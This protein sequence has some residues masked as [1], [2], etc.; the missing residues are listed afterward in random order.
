MSFLHVSGKTNLGSNTVDTIT[1]TGMRRT[2]SSDAGQ[3]L[4]IAILGALEVRR[5]DVVLGPDQLGGPKARQIL[6]ILLLNLGVP[7]SKGR[8]IDLLWDGAAPAAAVSTL[9]SYV[10][11]LRRCLQPGCGKSGPLKTATGGYLLDAT[12]ID[13][14]IVRFDAL[15]RRADLCPPAQ[16]YHCLSQA[17]ALASAPLLG[18]E[19]LPEW[20]EAERRLHHARV[21][22]AMV[23]AAHTALELGR[24]SEAID[25]SQRVVDADELNE[26][27]WTSMILALEQG[28]HPVSGLRAYERCRA[29][30]DQ[31]LGCS[32]GPVLQRAQARLLRATSASGDDFGRVVHALLAI[33]G[34]LDGH[35]RQEHPQG[36]RGS[37]EQSVSLQ[38]AGTIISGYL[39]R[40]MLHSV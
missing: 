36:S 27:A 29:V 1:D 8:L 7:V 26:A 6:E 10:S 18:N 16:A 34:V 40:A 33:Q 21:T 9:E 19:V 32:P 22:S 11:V 31:E 39:Q 13:L 28:G 30:M 5:G 3:H 23:Q 4:T 17:L 35:G 12:M 37:G 15:L 20:A 2:P 25:W 24:L 38:A 14:D